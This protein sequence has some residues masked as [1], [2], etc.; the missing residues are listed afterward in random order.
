MQGVSMPT[1]STLSTVVS[2]LFLLAMVALGTPSTTAFGVGLVLLILGWGFHAWI[3]R[4]WL[5]SVPSHFYRYLRCPELAGQF[6]VAVSW[7][8]LTEQVWLA[9]GWMLWKCVQWYLVLQDQEKCWSEILGPRFSFYQEQVPTLF[10]PLKAGWRALSGIPSESRTRFYELVKPNLVEL[11]LSLL[12][13]AGLAVRM[14]FH[15]GSLYAW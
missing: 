6:C 15:I 3:A 9:G 4:S 14:A 2:A 7:F 8:F 10:S 12:A 13:G 5:K 1:Y 11:G